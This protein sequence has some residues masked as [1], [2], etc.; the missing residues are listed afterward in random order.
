MKPVCCSFLRSYHAIQFGLRHDDSDAEYL[1]PEQQKQR[2]EEK[3]AEK[4]KSA[5]KKQAE[6]DRLER[7]LVRKQLEADRQARQLKVKSI[8]VLMNFSSVMFK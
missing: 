7:E 8:V 6:E 5:W 1:S 4:Q 3:Q 2:F